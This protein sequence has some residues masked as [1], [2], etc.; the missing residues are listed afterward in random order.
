MKN[1]V[2]KGLLID[3]ANQT[4][5]PIDIDDNSE[6]LTLSSLYKHIGCETV[7][8]V[9]YN[10]HDVWIDEEGLLKDYEYGFRLNNYSIVGRA[11]ILDHNY[12]GDTISHTLNDDDI[13]QLKEDIEFF[14]VVK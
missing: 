13:R 2:Q 1:N 3:P 4:I 11:I 7:E 10:Q 14:K 12:D 8:V 6:N 9:T 5:M